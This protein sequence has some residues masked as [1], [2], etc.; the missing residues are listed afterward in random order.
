MDAGFHVLISGLCF[1]L[2]PMGEEQV[3]DLG[4]VV[5]TGSGNGG[6]LPGPETRGKPRIGPGFEEAACANAGFGRCGAASGSFGLAWAG[7]S[8]VG[9]VEE[10][11]NLDPTHFHRSAFCSFTHNYFVIFEL[12]AGPD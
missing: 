9:K 10:K 5:G 1:G 4:V 11:R 7:R 6:M 12:N 2:G 3:D 8:R